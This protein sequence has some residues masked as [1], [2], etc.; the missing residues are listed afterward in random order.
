MSSF[1]LITFQLCNFWRQHIG[2]YNVDEIDTW[3]YLTI[4]YLGYPPATQCL[5]EIL[6]MLCISRKYRYR[7]SLQFENDVYA[8]WGT[9]LSRI[10]ESERGNFC[11]CSF[12]PGSLFSLFKRLLRITLHIVNELTW[13]VGLFKTV[14][15]TSF[16]YITCHWVTLVK[17]NY[18]MENILILWQYRWPL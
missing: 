14:L 7:Q 1:S 5:S 8:R 6:Q 11:K 3:A 12:P 4:T 10:R 17:F 2:V 15:E 9:S 16:M 13:K 18:V